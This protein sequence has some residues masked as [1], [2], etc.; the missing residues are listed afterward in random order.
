MEF[1]QLRTFRMVADMLSFSKAAERLFMAQS[2]VSAQIKSLEETLDIKLFDRIGRR[3]LLTDA[4]RKLYE[5]ARRIEEMTME[6]RSEMTDAK[7]G[8]GS[9]TIR[10]PETLATLYMPEVV[11]RF[12]GDNPR[13]KLNFI[14]CTDQQ[15][16]EELN[17]GRID[18]AF[19]MTD[20]VRLKEVNVRLLK[21]E[22]LVLVASPSHSLVRQKKVA[23]DDLNGQTLLLPKTDCSYRK[24]FER[25]LEERNV[26]AVRLEFAS[27]N[28]LRNCL[29]R[30]IGYTIC[31]DASV[32]RELAEE[33]LLKLGW[34]GDLLETSVIMIW[35]IE[36]WCS[37]LLKH[38]M[39][40]CE[41]IISN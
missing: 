9:L 1:R 31:P 11:E 28:S 37:P 14:N 32:Q 15:L 6:I 26:A 20:T 17:S 24:P 22:N 4:G 27:I 33:S 36:K 29:K 23:I 13:V 40:L 12:H 10:V 16:R 38:F 41:E 2:S 21:T 25:S 3:V 30:G 39:K 5:Y 8:R 7:N 18:A 35:H 34:H 19:L